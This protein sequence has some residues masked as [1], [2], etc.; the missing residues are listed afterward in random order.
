MEKLEEERACMEWIRWTKRVLFWTTESSL[1]RA[2]LT[3]PE[4]LSSSSR[5]TLSIA[6]R[7]SSWPC[8]FDMHMG[9]VDIPVFREPLAG[10]Q[11]VLSTKTGFIER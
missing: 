10:D 8:H 11:Q 9:Q 3:H 5:D 6:P 7:M 1:A 2:E 4:Y